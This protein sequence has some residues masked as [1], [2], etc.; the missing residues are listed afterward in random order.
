MIYLVIAVPRNS[1]NSADQS[2]PLFDHTQ[3][4]ILAQPESAKKGPKIEPTSCGNLSV[5]EGLAIPDLLRVRLLQP[6]GRGA[7]WEAVVFAI[8][9]WW[10]TCVFAIA[11]IMTIFQ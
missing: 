10:P 3:L 6:P 1:N 5:P 9:S 7:A 4:R 11:S 8:E 2:G